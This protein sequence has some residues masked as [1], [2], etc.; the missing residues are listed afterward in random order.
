M[1]GGFDGLKAAKAWEAEL[2]GDGVVVTGI[3]T[4]KLGFA[5]VIVK[6]HGDELRAVS[7]PLFCFHFS[8]QFF[9]SFQLQQL[10]YVIDGGRDMDGSARRR[11]GMSS[12]WE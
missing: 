10:G 7:S 5:A 8:S 2:H 12:F 6:S 4:A 11:R 3:G 1:V 9:S